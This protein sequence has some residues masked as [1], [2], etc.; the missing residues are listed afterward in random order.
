MIRLIACDIDG[1]LLP[2]GSTGLE[3]AVYTQIRRLS[4]RGVFFCPASGRQYSSLRRLFAPVAGRLPFLCEN[5]AVVFGPGSP[6]PIL[7]KTEMARE[8]A[9]ELCRDILAQP[10]CEVLISGA[11]TSYLCPKQGDIVTLVRDFVGNNVALLSAPE[12]MPEAIVKV[13]AYCRDAAADMVPLLA[14]RWST[15]F[16]SAVAGAHWLDFTLADKG[17]GL[18]QLCAALQIPLRDVAAFGDNY[19]DVPMLELAGTTYLMEGA[20]AELKARFPRHCAQVVPE[21]ARLADALPPRI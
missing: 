20:A 17:T 6:G 3:P 7:S 11:N 2:E 19:N 13:S 18:R 5:G 21:L 9:L 16:R 15:R 1:T 8:A 4:E 12:E 10:R 14:P